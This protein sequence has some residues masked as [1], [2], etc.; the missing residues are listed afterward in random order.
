MKLYL[1]RHGD[2]G[3]AGD[4]R[5][6][7]NERPL[8]EKGAQRTKELA[9][10]LRLME[11][12]FDFILSSPLAR[13]R[14]T[15]EIVA[16]GLKFAGK[17]E[18]TEYLAPFGSMDG[19]VRHLNTLRPLPQNILLV[20][21]EPYLSGFISL[22]CTGGPGLAITMKK[23]GLCRLALDLP[24]CEKCATLEWLL[25]PRVVGRKPAKR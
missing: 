4:P 9:H 10:E 11:I 16:R 24:R 15:A 23:G 12:S 19:L 25:T 13:A 3:E 8:T 22:L 7:E 2:A 21:H 14:E 6:K 18:L 17:V 5:Y 20:G 1:L